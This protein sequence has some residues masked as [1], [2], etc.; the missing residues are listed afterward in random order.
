MYIMILRS[1][2]IND[3]K[4]SY[5]LGILHQILNPNSA[6]T[7]LLN[8]LLHRNIRGYLLPSQLLVHL[9]QYLLY[10]TGS[11][12]GFQEGVSPSPSCKCQWLNMGL[13][14]CNAVAQSLSYGPSNLGGAIQPETDIHRSDS[15][16]RWVCVFCVCMHISMCNCPCHCCKAW[17]YGYFLIRKIA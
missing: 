17:S 12:L 2:H 4:K 10:F 13:S 9:T 5:L 15:K 8:S 14:E 3:F 7:A 16:G 11:S 1:G 6:I